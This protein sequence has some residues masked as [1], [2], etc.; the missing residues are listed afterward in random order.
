MKYVIEKERL[1]MTAEPQEQEYLRLLYEQDNDK[2]DR[3]QTFVDL[4]ENLWTNDSFQML[5]A[6][7]TGDLT[8]AP[9]LAILGDEE[10]APAA[11]K[12]DKELYGQC[13]YPCGKDEQGI[14]CQPILYR[15]A[16]MDYQVSSPQ[17]ELLENG[18]AVWQG[19]VM[20]ERPDN[21]LAYQER[22]FR[23]RDIL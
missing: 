3:D 1:V 11:I 9:M 12:D 10:R 22:E 4:F 13:L 20:L 16:F 15:W 2:F 23:L 5:G 19:G 6:E 8:D 14:R 7:W 17:R 18:R 21:A